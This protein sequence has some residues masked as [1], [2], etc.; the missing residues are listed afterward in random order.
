MNQ[1]GKIGIVAALAAVVAVVIVMKN[2][3]SSPPASQP[4]TQPASQPT[5]ALP[6]L[7]ALGATTCIPC[8]MKTPVLEELR[9]E[10]AGRLQ[11]EFI[12]VKAVPAAV[13]AYDIRVIPTQVF[14][15]AAGKERWRHEGFIA[16]DAILA[17]WKE[18]GID[19]SGTEAR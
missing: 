8:K 3:A 1:A 9:T 15:D 18:L 16:K 4:A 11:V 17:K 5:A 2:A 12:D 7:V 14:F 13:K 6:R 10:Y 19:L